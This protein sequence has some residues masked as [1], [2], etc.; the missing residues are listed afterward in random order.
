MGSPPSNCQNNNTPHI[1]PSQIIDDEAVKVAKEKGLPFALDYIG[2]DGLGNLANDLSKR[3]RELV[4]LVRVGF[5]VR[6]DGER[7]TVDTV[8]EPELHELLMTILQANDTETA[9]IAI[10]EEK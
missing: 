3:T 4:T 7:A 1:F 9:Y 6:I 10:R 2:Y 5:L 8:R